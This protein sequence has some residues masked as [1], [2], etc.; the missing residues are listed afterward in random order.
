M[1]INWIGFA[2]AALAA[3]VFFPCYRFAGN[4]T[5]LLRLVLVLFSF[6]IALP[7]LSFTV[8][9][10]HVLPETSWYYQFRSRD[11]VELLIVFIGVAGGFTAALLPRALCPFALIAV[12]GLGVI[13]FIKPVIG[14][15]DPESF[16][17]RWNGEVCLQ[18]TPSTCG[19]A[20]VATILR[21]LGAQ[22]VTERDLALESYSYAGGTE[23]WYMIRALRARGFEAEVSFHDDFDPEVP[24]PAV[25]GVQLGGPGGVGHFVPFLSREG[26]TFSIG[27]PAAGPQKLTLEQMR[28]RYHFTGFHMQISKRS[29]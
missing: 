11:G 19:P 4:R 13:P 8:Y 16:T 14:P 22:D 28:K 27:D 3:L 20:S 9:Y 5:V 29:E 17:D 23:A 26:D 15:L 25:I 24:L 21:G 2:S 12:I 6:I 10:A 7:A 1:N 18:S